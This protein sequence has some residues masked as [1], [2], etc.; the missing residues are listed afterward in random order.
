MFGFGN[1][2]EGLISS[3]AANNLQGLDS[4]VQPRGVSENTA[5]CTFEYSNISINN[6]SINFI[7]EEK[8][9]EINKETS[10]GSETTRDTNMSASLTEGEKLTPNPLIKD[11]SEFIQEINKYT[12]DIKLRELLTYY[13]ISRLEQNP[14]LSLTNFKA[15]LATLTDATC[16][17]EVPDFS[18]E[19]QYKVVI[20][21]TT[22]S[23]SQFKPIF[24]KKYKSNQVN[25]ENS[26]KAPFG[27]HSRCIPAGADLELAL[28]E[29]GNPIKF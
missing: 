18:M 28:D 6:N 7:N 26:N 11:K 15:S 8:I 2:Y 13:L 20:N 27:D 16:Y 5:P 17:C 9:K 10:S 4:K 21:A 25:Q 24:D 1:N 23:Y 12:Q 3:R 14:N 22:A 29:N 19:Y